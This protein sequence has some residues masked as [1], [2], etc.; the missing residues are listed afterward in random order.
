MNLIE[1]LKIAWP[2]TDERPHG[3]AIDT[4]WPVDTSDVWSVGLAGWVLG[5]TAAVEWSSSPARTGNPLRLLH[6][7][8]S[9]LER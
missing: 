3:A 1:I 9:T 7:R 6:A 8:D 2:D 5:D 4:P